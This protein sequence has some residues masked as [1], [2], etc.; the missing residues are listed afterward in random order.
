MKRRSNCAG[1]QGDGVQGDGVQGGHARCGRSCSA[2]AEGSYGAASR[3]ERRQS[4][5]DGRA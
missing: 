2:A 4:E 3:K 1:V 5:G